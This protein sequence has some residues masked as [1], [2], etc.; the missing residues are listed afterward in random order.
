[1]MSCAG[2][3]AASLFYQGR[4]GACRKRVRLKVPPQTPALTWIPLQ[5]RNVTTASASIKPTRPTQNV[6]NEVMRRRIAPQIAKRR[7][8]DRMPAGAVAVRMSMAITLGEPDYRRGSR[9][10]EVIALLSTDLIEFSI[11]KHS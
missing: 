4:S 8:I 2:P 10:V 1:M 6:I 3:G 11:A 5:A 9:P 7:R